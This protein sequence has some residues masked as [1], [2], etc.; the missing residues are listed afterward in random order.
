MSEIKIL[1]ACEYSGVVRDSFNKAGFFAMSCDL[2]PTESPGNHYQGSVFDILNDG[3]DMLIGH[4]PCT[5][6]SSAGL[7]FCNIENHGKKA[8]E[9]II[10]RNQAIEF[11]LKMYDA[12]IKHICLENPIGYISANILKPTQIIHPYYF[13]EKEMKRTALWLKFTTPSV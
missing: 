6:L 11:F 12:P 9:R 3:W 7:H 5:Y 4:P 8:I 2:L 13:G 10:K 1:V